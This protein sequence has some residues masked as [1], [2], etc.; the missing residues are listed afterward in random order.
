MGIRAHRRRQ[1]GD[2][3]LYGRDNEYQLEMMVTRAF[4]HAAS[5]EISWSEPLISQANAL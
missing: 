3:G 2:A 5:A 4:E 1:R